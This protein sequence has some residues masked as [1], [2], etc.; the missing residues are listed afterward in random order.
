MSPERM[1]GRS[2]IFAVPVSFDRSLAESMLE[3]AFKDPK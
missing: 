3:K 1:I 2:A